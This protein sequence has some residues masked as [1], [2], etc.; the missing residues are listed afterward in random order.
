ME[1]MLEYNNS[2]LTHDNNVLEDKT[3]ET[4][5]SD[6]IFNTINAY[7]HEE[8][9]YIHLIQHI[10]D[11]GTWEQHEY[12][13]DTSKSKS[14][15][16]HTMRF[17]LRN[18][19]I[20]II[21]TVKTEW[22]TCVKE[23]LWFIRG[24]TD[25]NLLQNQGVHIWDNTK[26]YLP[27]YEKGEL[28]P[29]HGHQWRWFNAPYITNQ[30]K[31]QASR[32]DDNT[33]KYYTFEPHGVDQLQQ[34]IDQLKNQTVKNQTVKN[35]GGLILTAWN[36]SQLSQMAVLPCNVLCQFNVHDGNKLSCSLYQR[37]CDIICDQHFNIASY[38]FLTHLIAT[39]C[40]L[41]AYE[42]VYFMANCH[43]SEKYIDTANSVI[44]RKP[45]TFPTVSINIKENINDYCIEDFIVANYQ[46]HK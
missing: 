41:E 25:A 27:N 32:V 26:Q 14:I 23:L 11:K 44:L 43:I 45:F 17:S 8:Y 20:P 46:S 40:G 13:Y 3:I 10:L 33:R 12:E 18:G 37:S 39:H 21:T 29:I 9:Q 15:F 5:V 7:K 16:G 19:Q 28:G 42:C 22:E 2:L 35:H 38:S 6:N 34:I 24:D 36:P 1:H 4:N 30:E 31:K